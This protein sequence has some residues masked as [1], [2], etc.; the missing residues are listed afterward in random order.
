MNPVHVK[1]T[2]L[3]ITFPTSDDEELR[4]LRIGLDPARNAS[5]TFFSYAQGRKNGIIAGFFKLFDACF[6]SV[7]R[8]DF[9]AQS[10]Q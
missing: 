10:R 2:G 9:A 6:G 3:K 4:L 7:D 8:K 5:R 1:K